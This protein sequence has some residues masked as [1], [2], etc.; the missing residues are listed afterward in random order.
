MIDLTK[1]GTV[2][3]EY[4]NRPAPTA[5]ASTPH[6]GVDVVVNN[7]QTPAVTAGTVTDK[8]TD[9]SRGNWISI[10]DAYGNVQT[11]MHMKNSSSL[12]A[13]DKVAEGDI[14]G[15]MGSTGISTGNHVH[16]QV[17]N[18][19]GTYIN[20]ETYFSGGIDTAVTGSRPRSGESSLGLEW[21]GDIVKVVLMA[22]LIIAG[23]A[24]F[25]MGVLN[26]N[27]LKKITGGKK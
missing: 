20:P 1:L 23:V 17:Y 2:T 15:T 22:L 16:F 11:Y 3:S 4:G 27:P 6:K 8:G 21:W 10:R 25:A 9:S 18:A 7:S 14:I 26:T 12:S 5:G 24:M 19:Q 13:G